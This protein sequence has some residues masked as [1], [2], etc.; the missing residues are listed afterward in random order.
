MQPGGER[1]RC[2][3]DQPVLDAAHAANVLVP[4]SCRGGRCGTC[5]VSLLDGEVRYPNG[6]PD[7]LSD[8]EKQAGFALLCSAY[9]LTDLVIELG[10]PEMG[11]PEMA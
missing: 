4:Y 8:S 5:R 11:R 3:D 6:T 2:R 10:R 9:A 7:A 1:F